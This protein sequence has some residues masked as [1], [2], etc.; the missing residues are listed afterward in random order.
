MPIQHINVLSPKAVAEEM[1]L[2]KKEQRN[3]FIFPH[4]LANQTVKTVEVSSIPDIYNGELLLYSIIRDISEF[5]EAQDGLWHSE[6]L[7]GNGC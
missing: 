2:A 5:R 4:H 1:A 6:S 7:G 3:Y